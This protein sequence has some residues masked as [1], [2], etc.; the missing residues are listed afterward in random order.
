MYNR[1]GMRPII[2]TLTAVLINV[3]LSYELN[4]KIQPFKHWRWLL[5]IFLVQVIGELIGYN[6]ENQLVG[7]FLLHAIG[8]GVVT[9]ILYFYLSLSFDYKPRIRLQLISLFLLVSCTGVMN[10]LYE[11]VFELFRVGT[12]SFDSH[13]TWRDLVANT[14]GAFVGWVY[15]KALIGFKHIKNN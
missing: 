2:S 9:S 5:A 7:N 8:G 11:Y 12:Y 14:T 1:S 13:D 4:K 10:E 6:L 3:W 15:I